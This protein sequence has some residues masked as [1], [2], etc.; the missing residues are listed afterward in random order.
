MRYKLVSR[1]NTGLIHFQLIKDRTDPL[2]KAWMNRQL[3]QAWLEQYRDGVDYVGTGG[4]LTFM[5]P[6]AALAFRLRWC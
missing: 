1:P 5:N 3:V 6:D 4:A 2:S